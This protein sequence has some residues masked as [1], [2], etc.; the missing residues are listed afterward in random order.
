MAHPPQVL[1]RRRLAL[2]ARRA[3]ERRGWTQEESA[4]AVGCSVQ[5]IRRIER[6]AVNSSVD[7]AAR[8]AAAYRV[9]IAEMFVLAGPWSR[10]RVGRPTKRAGST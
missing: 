3:R 10:R 7:L 4:E 8:L 6:A 9:D 1:A 5:Q 2:N